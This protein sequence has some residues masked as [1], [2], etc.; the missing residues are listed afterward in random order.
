MDTGTFELQ[1]LSMFER[2]GLHAHSRWIVDDL[3]RRIYVAERGGM[4]RPVVLIHGGLTQGGDWCFM[5]GRLSGHVVIPDRPGWGLTYRIDH[6]RVDFREA[7]VQW[8]GTL[9]DGLELNEVDLVGASTGGFVAAMFAL[10]QPKRVTHLVLVG[11]T[12]GLQHELPLVLRL[13]GHPVAGRLMSRMKVTDPEVHRKRVFATLVVHPEAVP[14]DFLQ[15]DID[16]WA[17]DGAAQSAYTMMRSISTLRGYRPNI[18]IADQMARLS[19]PT[20]FLWG[21]ADSY[22]PLSVGQHVADTMPDAQFQMVPDAGHSPHVDQPA[23]VAEAIETF[24]RRT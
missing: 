12:M 1:R 21:D 2:Y 22:V 3:G 10:A 17:L 7:S 9:L 20:L 11:G 18:M 6:R 13:M 8:L 23:M 5:A 19:C 16:A 14:L 15:I 24:I 4:E